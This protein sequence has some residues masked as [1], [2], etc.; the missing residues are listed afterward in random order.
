MDSLAIVGMSSR[1][2]RMRRGV[3]GEGGHGKCREAA[4]CVYNGPM[5]Y[6]RNY[7]DSLSL[8]RFIQWGNYCIDSG[9][10]SAQ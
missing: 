1:G 9:K 6:D 5:W 8:I 10:M 3:R 2:G 4:M 7:F